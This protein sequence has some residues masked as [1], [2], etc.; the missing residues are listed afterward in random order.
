MV[1]TMLITPSFEEL[2]LLVVPNFK[3]CFEFQRRKSIIG[4]TLVHF[5]EHA[6]PSMLLV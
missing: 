4:Q 3:L 6:C 1:C 5:K 2:P